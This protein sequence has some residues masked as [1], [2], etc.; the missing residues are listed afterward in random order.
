MKKVIS[1]ATALVIIISLLILPAS[2]A[3]A[4]TATAVPDHL[5]LSWTG[6][7]ATTQTFTWRTDTTAT[8][9]VVQ[10]KAGASA[11]LST[12]ASLVT[13][14]FKLYETD[15]G[16]ENIHTATA[17]GLTPGTTYTYKVGDGTTWSAVST[18]T[19]AAASVTSFKFLIFGD[20]QPNYPTTT[21]YAPW[22]TTLTNAYA[23][24]PD[25]KFMVNMGDTSE[26]GGSGAMWDKFFDAAKDVL[27]KLPEMAVQGN[28]DT[29]TAA[30]AQ[31]MPLG[32]RNQFTNPQN[33]P[34]V[35]KDSCYSY[36]Y[37]AVHF[38]VLDSQQLE[39]NAATPRRP[40]YSD[41]AGRMAE[42]GSGRAYGRAVYHRHDA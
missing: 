31:M 8:A 9:G 34:D 4:F 38:V 6:D 39:E 13:G 14:T 10:Y 20:S 3:D 15:L 26:N 25:A 19:T 11:D 21:Y 22:K 33:G 16:K 37:G 24:N 41:A 1:I 5:V 12:G 2:A 35:V 28:H 18:F 7:P 32:F 30:Y 17:T 27:P 29:F 23:A 36:D 42:S 40:R